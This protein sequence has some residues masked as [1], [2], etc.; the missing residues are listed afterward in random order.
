MKGHISSNYITHKDL[1][2]PYIALVISGGH[3]YIIDVKDYDDF[4]KMGETVFIPMPDGVRKAKITSTV[5]Y[6]PAN[7]RLKA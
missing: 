5:F 2:P 7:D 4:D 3:S 6:D 1:E